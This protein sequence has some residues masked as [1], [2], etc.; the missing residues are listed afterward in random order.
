MILITENEIIGEAI[1]FNEQ[2]DLIP[3]GYNVS[4]PEPKLN[5]VEVAGRNGMLDLTNAIGAVTYGNRNVWFSSLMVDL[6]GNL[7][8]RFSEI[9]NKYHGQRCKIVLDVEPEYYYDGR[10]IISRETVDKKN[11]IVRVDLD[12]DPF[13]YPVYASDEDWLWN[14][15]NFETGVI[16]K[17][18]NI[19]INNSASIDVIAYDQ[20][21][22]PRFY[23]NLDGGQTSMKMVYDGDTYY[24]SNGLNSF[25]AIT[26][27]SEDVHSDIHRFT[28]YGR[29]I[30]SINIRGGIL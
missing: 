11:Q 15:F 6:D 27:Q 1:D 8:K 5:L 29:G 26:I 2:Y 4:V 12:A 23:V 24:L 22:S 20:P 19:R 13:K 18:K 7:T 9:L 14:P 21:E 16:R 3:M 25:P 10:C 30:V 17:Y 28:F